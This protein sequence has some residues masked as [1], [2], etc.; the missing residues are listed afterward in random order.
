MQNSVVLLITN[1]PKEESKG[2]IPGKLFEYLATG[3]QILSFGPSKADVEKIIAETQTG[4]HFDFNADINA[5]KAYLLSE[6]EIWKQDTH[7]EKTPNILSYS[8]KYLTQKLVNILEN[9]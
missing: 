5:L 9:K 4:K 3:K 1:F 2:I 7:R 6:Y 8:R